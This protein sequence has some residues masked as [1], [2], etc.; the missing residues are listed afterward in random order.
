MDNKRNKMTK[1][2]DEMSKR[3][4]GDGAIFFNETKKKWVGQITLGYDEN[5]NRKRKTVYG[6]TKSEVKQKLKQ[7]EIGVFTGEFVDKSN[8]TIYQ[9]AKQ[10]LDDDYNANIIK[11]NTYFRHLETLRRL[12]DIYNTPLQK[13]N[14][15]QIKAF[16]LKEQTYSQ[17][18]I[19]KEYRLLNKT[20]SEAVKKGIITKSPMVDIRKPKTSQKREKTRALTIDEQN[21]LLSVLLNE[22]IKYSHQ[23]L[24]SMLTGMRMG[25]INALTINDVNLNFRWLNINK[26]ITRGQKGE[27][28][29]GDTAKTD[30]GTRNIPITND[31]LRV[32]NEV[33]QISNNSNLLF[34]KNNDGKTLLNTSE[35]N[36]AFQRALKKYDIIDGSVSGKVTCHSLRHTYATRCIES[37]MQPNTLKKLLGHEDI[38]TTLN[39]YCDVFEKLQNDN[40]KQYE[41]YMAN[42]GITLTEQSNDT[43]KVIKTA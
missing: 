36:N 38:E 15:M 1:E 11:E 19:D 30:A 5:G 16:L 3:A 14:D 39:T 42:L 26:T 10:I 43:P 31:V 27:A 17:S 32:L 20:F 12:K 22:D 41:T 21:K 2:E 8:I 37:G 35:V 24:L 40:V 33:I 9:L 4:N 25:E 34:T 6:S 29:M 28:I 18:T 13:A 7:I 23:L